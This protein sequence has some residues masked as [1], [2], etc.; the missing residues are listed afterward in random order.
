M[1]YEVINDCRLWITVEAE[2]ANHAV[3]IARNTDLS[4]W[5]VGDRDE[6][7]VYEDETGKTCEFDWGEVQEIIF[8]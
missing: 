3:A 5:Q 4:T 7:E 8:T 2:D 1:K 6:I